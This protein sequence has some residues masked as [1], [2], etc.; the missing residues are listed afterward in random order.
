[1]TAPERPARGGR[2]P[3]RPQIVLEVIERI[4]LTPHLV[5]IVAG[6]P[7]YWLAPILCGASQ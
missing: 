2:R 6:G 4:R 3:E 7:G 5:R 1:M